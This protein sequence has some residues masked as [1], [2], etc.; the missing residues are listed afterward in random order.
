MKKLF[1]S[2]I[3][4]ISVTVLWAQKPI[5]IKGKIEN[6]TNS[7]YAFIEKQ[8]FNVERLEG[9]NTRIDF[10][11]AQDGSFS[12][13][14]PKAD[15]FYVRYFIE[16]GNEKTHMDLIAGDSIY[17]TL[18]ATFFDESIKYT[19]RGAGRNNYRR[20]VFLEFWDRNAT[21]RINS[22]NPGQFLNGL[23]NLRERK[24]E[25]LN[26]Y[27][28][29]G[30]ID[31]S[32]YKY[33][34]A[35]IRNEMA[36]LILNNNNNFHNHKNLPDSIS[37]QMVSLLKAADFSDDHFMQRNEFRELITILPG[38]MQENNS[39]I[40]DVDLNREIDFA[41]KHYTATMQLYFNKENIRKYL[42]QA[43][44]ISEKNALLNFFDKQFDAPILKKEI[45]EQRRHLRNDRI[46]NSSIFQGSMILISF[47][48][49]VLAL[50]FVTI[51]VIQFS[52]NKRIKINLALWLKVVFYLVVSFF[53]LFYIT[54][55][56]DP[57]K[58]IPIV[59]LQLGIF[60]YHTYVL[61]PNYALKGKIRRYLLI[62]GTGLLIFVV[63]CYITKQVR[64]S[65]YTVLALS[66]L[67]FGCIL[68]SWTSYY[69]NQLT[70][71][72]ATLKELI[73]NGDLNLEIALNLIAVFLINSIF[74]IPINHNGMLN[75]VLF[76]YTII[77]LFYFHTFISFPRTFSKKRVIQFLG[78]NIGILLGASII[79]ILLDTVQSYHALKS[80]GVVT[81]P[82]E[83]F[84]TRN[85]RPDLL[86]VFTMLLIPSF[87][88][89]YI[90]RQMA[91]MD[92]TGF[93]LYRKKE[94]ELAHLRS[95]V[96]P[97]FLFNTLNTLYAFAL[98]EGSDKTAECIAKLANLM[99]FMLDDMEKE[100]ILLKR[101][102]RYIQDYVK[103]QSIRSAV[104]H[105]IA[106]NVEMDE[107]E[108]C[109]I[110]PMLLIPFVENAFKH[111]MNPN[112]VSQ[113]K[114]DIRA[115]G[116]QIQFVIENS[117]DENFEAYYKEKGFG[118]GIENVKSRLKYVYPD[119]HTISIAKTNTNFIVILT[120]EK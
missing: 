4:F 110:A 104:E 45:Q 55:S 77:L 30:E 58:G 26:K 23:N 10:P 94:A 60:L 108:G 96:N 2:I 118:I 19:G 120:I 105:E 114:I 12:V 88:Y 117:I 7:N 5:V 37:R 48:V 75:Q 29:A 40:P 61:I 22:S 116:Q 106:I 82:V 81:K 91:S 56:R 72:K 21:G 49:L 39:I 99:R 15:E 9:E 47:F 71:Q 35:Q 87:V 89:F 27:H 46:K 36:N 66:D 80:I 85:I 38:Y 41:A 54:N 111:G 74:I 76:F 17:M 64:T 14:I 24:L 53:S 100:S 67:Y 51:K 16:L 1:I 83:L 79:M 63:G 93:Q 101:E 28:L 102:I 90:K 25:L 11:I 20:D 42:W 65:L 3:A 62:T 52:G 59:L 103:L 43:N 68:L 95:Q 70:T 112:K 107:E 31:S 8:G 33:E 73:K 50:L 57:F 92:T 86:I 44:S 69:I 78:I 98:K 113:L 13:S 84:S 109:S 97:H 32:Y 34:N 119:R 6:C 18:N 115:I